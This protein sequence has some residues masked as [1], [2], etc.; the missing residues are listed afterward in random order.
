MVL[1]ERLAAGSVVRASILARLLGIR[2]LRLEAEILLVPTRVEGSGAADAPVLT[3]RAP[4]LV[5]DVPVRPV[6]M[7]DTRG[8]RDAELL[9]RKAAHT[10]DGSRVR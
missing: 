2:L 8:L 10:L 9:L 3:P 4:A 7:D 5:S 6:H 1:G